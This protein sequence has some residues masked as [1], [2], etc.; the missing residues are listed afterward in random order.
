MSMLWTNDELAQLYQI[1]QV[2]G[3]GGDTINFAEQILKGRSKEAIRK[4]LKRIETDDNRNSGVSVSFNTTGENSKEISCQSQRIT[5]LDQLLKYCDVDREVWVVDHYIVNKWEVG[6][7][8]KQVDLVWNNGVPS[9]SVYS[10]GNLVVEPLI[11]I[12]VWLKRRT[13]VA[14]MPTI[15]PIECNMVLR[16]LKSPPK[17][18]VT[19]K[20]VKR[21]LLLSDM[22]IGYRKDI[23]SAKLHPFHDR[24][25]LDLA[26]Q[27][28]IECEPDRIDILGDYLDLS[29]WTD[30]FVRS[31][32][33]AHTTQPT[34][35]EGYW[36]LRLLRETF[37]IRELHVKNDDV[38][39]VEI[40]L[41]QGNHDQRMDRLIKS[42][43]DEA[44][45]LKAADEIDMPPALSVQKL[46]ALH[47]LRIHWIDGYPNDEDWVNDRIYL[48]HGAVA[49]QPGNTAKSEVLNTDCIEFSGHI[50]RFEVVIR[51]VHT[52]V[53][54]KVAL[55]CCVPCLSRIDGSVP[56]SKIKQSWSQGV[57]I[58]DYE[59][60]GEGYS[61]THVPF[62][63]GQAWYNGKHFVGK[64]RVNEIAKAFPEWNWSNIE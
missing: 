22:Q 17:R 58:V 55:V 7:K 12:K 14:V 35:C 30:K 63:N 16:T 40:S 37:P 59:V 11:Q 60:D 32:E 13:P 25:C 20:K 50:H 47:S 9:G 3:F 44:Y 45:E 5:T 28:A 39:N 2:Y 49:R 38:E 6:A 1:A 43:F 23:K 31:P 24:I 62:E 48:C 36:W 64:D 41:H 33:F 42:H 52:R 57:V 61:F 53:G 29:M 56:G 54:E 21:A 26:V 15:H 18:K 19:K 51:R 34:I 10:D 46:L 27:I 4:K 8:N